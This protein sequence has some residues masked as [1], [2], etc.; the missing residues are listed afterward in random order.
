MMYRYLLFSVLFAAFVSAASAQEAVIPVA[1]TQT[2]EPLGSYSVTPAL[3]DV[4]EE[5][6][7]KALTGADYTAAAE[8]AYSGG[9]YDRALDNYKKALPLLSDPKEQARVHERLAFIYSAFGKTDS[10]Y[11][12]FL[13]ALKLDHSLELDQNMVSPKIYESFEKAKDEV[14]REGILICNCDPSGAEVY[15]DGALLGEA[16]VKKEHLPEGEHTLTLKKAGL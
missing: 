7:E 13:E 15:L 12:E 6:K 10:M 14:V 8:E 1:G 3:H 16:P 11:S 4:P 9:D 5:P 2:P